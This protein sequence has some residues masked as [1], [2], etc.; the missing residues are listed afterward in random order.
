MSGKWGRQTPS[1]LCKMKTHSPGAGHGAVKNLL[2]ADLRLPQGCRPCEISQ[3][4]G[5]CPGAGGYPPLREAPAACDGRHYGHGGNGPGSGTPTLMKVL[6][7]SADP[8]RWIRCS[9]I[10]CTWIRRWCPPKPRELPGIGTCLAEE[11]SV[12]V[13][14]EGGSAP[15]SDDGGSAPSRRAGDHGGA[16]KAVR[17]IPTL[18]WTPGGI[19]APGS[20]QVL[21]DYDVLYQTAGH[22]QEEMHPLRNLC[23]P[24]PGAG[25]SH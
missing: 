12:L 5:L 10:W 25:K 13:P 21:P 6:L 16:G 17:A 24:L 8:V 14:D 19:H 18:T 4:H 1:N 9:V 23:Q 2:R 7:F 11:I 22:R 15:V 20:G 3:C